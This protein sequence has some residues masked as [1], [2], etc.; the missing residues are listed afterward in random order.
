MNKKQELFNKMWTGLEAQGWEQA[1]NA[2]GLCQ[3]LTENGLRCAVGHCLSN[4]DP[5][6]FGGVASLIHERPE[7]VAELG[8]HEDEVFQ[9]LCRAQLKHD[10]NIVPSEMRLAFEK[11]ASSEGLVIPGEAYLP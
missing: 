1:E 2:K 3:Y 4:P 9:F 5:E 11:L 7:V 8:A 6:F 10:E